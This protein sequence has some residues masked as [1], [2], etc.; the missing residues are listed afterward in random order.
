MFGKKTIRDDFAKIVAEI[1]D[2]HRRT[3]NPDTP[4][5]VPG[6]WNVLRVDPVDQ[7]AFDDLALFGATVDW[8]TSD[9]WSL[10]ET[11]DT[12]LRASY[13]DSP[14][15]GRRWIVFYNAL[16]VGWLEISAA[17]KRLFRSVEEF[18]ADP[19]ARVDMRLRWMRFLPA[20][21]VFVFLSQTTRLMQSLEG[22]YDAAAERANRSAE[23]TMTRHLW[24]VMR[25][26]DQYVPDL[27]YSI[28]GPYAIF[29]QLVAH[30]AETG[31]DPLK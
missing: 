29:R 28:D 5:T 9:A 4:L 10:E 13:H 30:W 20:D 22:G 18:R 27:D 14:A 7:A 11:S 21:E 17:P 16:D 24:D 6:R 15:Y 8:S 19:F 26:G 2:G 31:F 3:P 25:V 12:G 1:N 23:S